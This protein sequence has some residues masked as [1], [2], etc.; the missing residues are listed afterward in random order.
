MREI[1]FRGKELS[2]GQWVTGFYTQGGYLNPD[3]GEMTVRHLIHADVLHDIDPNTLGQFTGLHD[4]D[5]RD[6]YEGDLVEMM[7]TP[8]KMRKRVM[9]RHIVKSW[10]VCDWVFESLTKE[11]LGLCMANHSDFDSYRFTVVGNIYDNPDMAKEVS[12]NIP[13]RKH[14]R[15]SGKVKLEFV[16]DGVKTSTTV[17]QE[18]AQALVEEMS[19]HN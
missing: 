4:K 18:T 3:T 17:S 15:N 11:V 1:R 16:M 8:E 10:S 13:E 9:T 14:K 19:R 6:I 2:S 12:L 5:G 7:R